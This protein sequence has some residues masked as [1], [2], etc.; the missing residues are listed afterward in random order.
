MGPQNVQ[1]TSTPTLVRIFLVLHLL[2]KFL[3]LCLLIYWVAAS[4]LKFD[5]AL[6]LPDRSYG[7]RSLT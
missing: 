1:L 4:Y 5:W 2:E 6:I 3:K 7:Q